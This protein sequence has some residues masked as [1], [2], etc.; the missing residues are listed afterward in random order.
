MNC[1]ERHNKTVQAFENMENFADRHV[2]RGKRSK[3][4]KAKFGVV[5]VTFCYGD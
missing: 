5:I 1:A 3:L 4:G 2:D